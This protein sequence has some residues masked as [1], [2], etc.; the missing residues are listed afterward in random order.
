MKS[1]LIVMLTHND[2]T[3]KDAF[4][5]FQSCKD[6]PVQFWGCKDV[7][8]PEKKVKDLCLSYKEAGKTTFLE[9]VSY[10]KDECLV[11][12][13][14]AVKCKF[15]F[16][17]GTIFYPEVWEFLKNNQV[18]YFP[19]V[20]KVSG[21]PSILEGS[22]ESMIEQSEVFR[23]LG[24][25]GIDLLAFRRKNKPEDL[26]RDFIAKSKI[27]V[28]LAGSISSFAKINFVNSVNPWAFTM[29]SAL[30]TREYDPKGDF[31]SNLIKVLEKM[32]SIK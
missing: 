26:A 24:I 9:V 16:L 5:V 22:T 23:S 17:M 4:E 2:K 7:G 1:Q 25:N 30:F 3:V 11:G 27:P 10:S 31:R 13:K 12:A 15:D 29:G 18:K 8:L 20:G 19:F 21:S 28:V 14:L 6:L 32:D